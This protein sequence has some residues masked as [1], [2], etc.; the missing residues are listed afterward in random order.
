[1]LTIVIP[2]AIDFHSWLWSL[3]RHNLFP[4]QYFQLFPGML[5]Q[6][7][8]FPFTCSV[9]IPGFPRSCRYWSAYLMESSQKWTLWTENMIFTSYIFSIS[10]IFVHV[11]N[12]R[13]SEKYQWSIFTFFWVL[14]QIVII[15]FCWKILIVLTLQKCLTYALNREEC[16]ES[17][18]ACKKEKLVPGRMFSLCPMGYKSSILLSRP[19]PPLAV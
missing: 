10:M 15:L 11:N 3:L 8:S 9:G 2:N 7:G 5:G 17:I 18:L 6:D 19:C 4:I 14:C 1:M 16:Y 13:N 12:F